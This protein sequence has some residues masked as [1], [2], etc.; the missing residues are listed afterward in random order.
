M[1]YFLRVDFEGFRKIID[2]LGG[3]TVDV[4][5]SFVDYQYPDY[6]FGYQ[7]IKFEKGKQDFNGEK[8]LQFAR[9]RKGVTT[10]GSGGISE[11]SD[12]ARSKR[13][14]KIIFAAKQKFF[15]LGTLLNPVKI[16]SILNDL[17][18]HVSTN[19][20]IWE[21]IRFTDMAKEVDSGSVVNKVIDN[22]PG[23]LLH[24]EIASETG[25]YVLVPNAGLGKYAE[26]QAVAK[27]FFSEEIEPT[28]IEHEAA[29]LAIKNGTKETGLAK[30]IATE[31]ES[32]EFTIANAENALTQTGNEKTVIYDFTDGN[33]PQALR[34][35]KEQL[36]ANV[37]AGIP[38]NIRNEQKPSETKVDFLVII[39]NDNTSALRAARKKAEEDAEAAEAAAE[40][41]AAAESQKATQDAASVEK[42]AD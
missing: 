19:M 39:G 6:N 9:S 26:I 4:E 25:A 23:G 32:I 3:I 28:T 7:T 24:S 18:D 41:E 36:N 22:G 1:H 34:I 5:R 33:K 17:G 38:V 11:G 42:T 14:Q 2:D 8:A 13:Q 21:M 15:S 27:T 16:N 29:T 30:L 31:L 37:A 40:T 20:E 10:E 12:F 35:L